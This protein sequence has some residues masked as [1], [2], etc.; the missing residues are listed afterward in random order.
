MPHQVSVFAENKPGKLNRVTEILST[1]NINIR[2]ITISDTGDY[3]I[4]KL[5]IDKPIEG[6][7]YLQN[8]GIAS[9]LVSIVAIIIDDTPG[10]LHKA[11]SLL[12]SKNVNVE[13]AYGFTIREKNH[14]VFVFQVKD[15]HSTEKILKDAGFTII[16]D[17]E[18]YYL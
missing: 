8:A 11:T 18:L 5:L 7:E 13:D 10:G 6:N 14:A 1:N 9:T 17:N 2:A 15:V 3:G 16:S 4:I 12:S